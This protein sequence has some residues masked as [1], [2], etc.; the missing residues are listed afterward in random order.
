M[1]CSMPWPGHIFHNLKYV[2][3]TLEQRG[4]CGPCLHNVGCRVG[5]CGESLV[6]VG[7]MIGALWEPT[8]A[9]NSDIKH[10]SPS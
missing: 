2:V 3:I 7:F 6:L 10:V 8:T 1:A 4:G 9:D 5:G